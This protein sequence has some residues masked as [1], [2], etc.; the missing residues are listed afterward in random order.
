MIGKA[1]CFNNTRRDNPLSMPGL[2]LIRCIIILLLRRCPQ[3]R[4]NRKSTGPGS[5]I[6]YS[7]DSRRQFRPVQIS[8]SPSPIACES[9]T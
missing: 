9:S 3:P 4:A 7:S 8:N 5:G 1:I 6:F 2:L